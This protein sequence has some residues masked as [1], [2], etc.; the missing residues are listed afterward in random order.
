LRIVREPATVSRAEVAA[1]AVIGAV[2][3]L[4][5]QLGPLFAACDLALAVAMLDRT[6]ASELRA[7]PRLVL[8]V[9]AALGVALLLYIVWA[10]VSGS[11][12][13]GLT[14]SLGSNVTG[15]FHEVNVSLRESVGV[16]SLQDVPVPHALYLAWLVIALAS[17]AAAVLVSPWRLR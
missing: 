14:L 11:F 2:V 6:R 15:A 10:L 12:H 5:W 9:S 3:V 13:G 17:G 16:F 1:I 7:R 4:A 8:G